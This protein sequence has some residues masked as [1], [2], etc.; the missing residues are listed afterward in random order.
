VAREHR[1]F[2]AL[3]R[4]RI[5]PKVYAPG[6]E[7]REVFD[8]SFDRLVQM[9]L[10]RVKAQEATVAPVVEA[11]V[12]EVPEDL[13]GMSK[14]DLAVLATKLGIEVDEIEGSGSS[15]NVLK[16]DLIAAIESV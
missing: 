13:D 12:V 11:P 5:G 9:G 6:E 7:V 14:A 16:S 4:V 15:G 3:A 1:M 8:R 10:L 2:E